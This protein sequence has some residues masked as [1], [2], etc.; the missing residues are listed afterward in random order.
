MDT[1]IKGL[2]SAEAKKRLAKYGPNAIEEREESW[3]HRLFCRFW[4]P[5]PWMI[6]VAAI[7]SALA[8]RWEDFTIILILLLVNAFVDFYQESKAL[9]AIAVLKKKL[10]RKA[11]VLRDGH[12]IEIDAKE[13]VPGDVVKVRIGDIVPADMKL[14]GGGDFLQ[15]DQSALTGESLPVHKKA[16]DDLY[17]NAIIKQGEML[18]EVTGTGR[19]TYF[20]RTVALFAKAQME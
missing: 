14:L 6:E 11:I 4:G 2:T 12:W 1:N 17:A 13:I 15:V 8:K 7:L 18:G 3:W 16:G 10:A 20:G 19:N 9:N 5:I